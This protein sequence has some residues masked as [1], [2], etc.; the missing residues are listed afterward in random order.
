MN[1]VFKN[2]VFSFNSNIYE[3]LTGVAMGT[4]PS[5]PHPSY[6]LYCDLEE[7]FLS[8]QKFLPYFYTRY[9]DDFFLWLHGRKKLDLF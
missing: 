7:A 2:N 9:I 3:Q 5:R 4:P 6:M 1:F 8:T